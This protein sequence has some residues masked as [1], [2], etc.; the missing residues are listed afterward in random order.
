MINTNPHGYVPT[1][2]LFNKTINE[3]R[4]HVEYEKF[5]CRL[6]IDNDITRQFKQNTEEHKNSAHRFLYIVMV[7]ELSPAIH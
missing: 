5:V 1:A 2:L 6:L 7:P 4:E 3:M